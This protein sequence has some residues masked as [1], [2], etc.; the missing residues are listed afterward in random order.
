MSGWTD[1]WKGLPEEK[2]LVVVRVRGRERRDY[3]RVDGRWYA[4]EDLDRWQMNTSRYWAQDR[5][6]YLDTEQIEGW[7]ARGG[8]DEAR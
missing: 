4:L 3:Y 1:V 7:Q 2:E 6:W 5:S 8:H